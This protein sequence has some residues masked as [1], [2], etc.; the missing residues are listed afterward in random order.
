MN[1]EAMVLVVGTPNIKRIEPHPVVAIGNFDGV[2][3]GHQQI[4]SEAVRRAKEAGGKAVAVTFEPHP[5][6][7]LHPEQ[8]FRPLTTFQIKSRLIEGAGIEFLLVADFTLAFASQSPEEFVKTFLLDRMGAAAVVVGENFAFGRDRSGRA[9]DLLRLG[10]EQGL[11]VH[12]APPVVVD[13]ALASST[14]IRTLLLEGNVRLANHLLGRPYSLEGKVIPGEG[15]G[16]ELGYPTANFR[17]PVDLII[18]KDGVYAARVMKLAA[19][20][21]QTVEGIVYIGRRPTFAG[22]ETLIEVNL[23]DPAAGSEP[24]LGKR[25]LIS[26][27]DQI[28]GEMEFPSATELISQMEKDVEIAKERLK[29]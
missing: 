15:R 29:G 20:G 19:T 9:E 24:L 8:E 22:K 6:R 2:H 23:F 17:P 11:A 12:L 10:R 16:R 4:L 18:P 7:V 5:F 28:R 26:F 14:R 1:F 3:L 25:F 13:G 21:P 27:V